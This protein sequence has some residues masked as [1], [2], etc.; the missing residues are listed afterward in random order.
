MFVID[1]MDS[2]VK[3]A[4]YLHSLGWEYDARVVVFVALGLLAMKIRSERFHSVFVV[5]AI[6][7]E[8]SYILRLSFTLS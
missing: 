2:L 7:Y 3:G 5:L 8:I 1:V 6:I 4:A